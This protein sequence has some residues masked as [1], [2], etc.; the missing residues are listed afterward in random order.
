[1]LKRSLLPL[2]G[3]VLAALGS[4]S[5]AQGIS[6]K[7]AVCNWS[8][9]NRCVAI[10]A[11]GNTPVVGTVT[12]VPS[13]TQNVNLAQVGGN[14]VTTTVPVSGTVAATQSGTWNL[15]NISG[16]ISLPTGAATAANQATANA[17]LSSI[18]LKLPASLGIKTSAASLSVAPSSDGVWPASQSGTWNITNV[19]GTVSLPTGAA[20]AAA[21]TTGNASL[22]SIDTK[23]TAPLSVN[24]SV[25]SG[26]SD[27]GNPVKGG[28]VF[29][30]TQPTVT[31][32]QRVDQQ[33]TNRGE[34]LVA[35]SNGASTVGIGATTTDAN[36]AANGL[37]VTPRP[38]VF[39][40][41]TWD[42][43]RSVQGSDGTGLGVTAVA[44]VPSSAASSAITP[45]VTSA[46]ASSLVAKASAG[47][48]YGFQVTSG[49]SAG[50]V[51]LFNA[52][53]LPG[54]GAVTP[55]KCYVLAANS[56]LGVDF[57]PGPMMR[58]GT[59][60]TI[61]FSTTGCFTLTASATA[62]ISS[63]VQ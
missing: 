32:G 1:M 28:G 25:A 41:S 13:G 3:L 40:G 61:G 60:L 22:S 63:E 24:G 59:G 43:A 46:V 15:T 56:T 16:T 53:S 23:L 42:R 31:T 4:P 39:N 38:F 33:M 10:D 2:L 37:N 7:V 17:S 6:Q 58:F 48:L 35:I 44:T 8:Y 54:D 52:T 26:A 47:N 30:T 5:F 21:Q 57:R 55:I 12:V 19:T 49:A 14:A 27:S 34:A 45:V 20:T 62:F 9:A 51:L 50:Y 29:N 11:S 18:D 36:A